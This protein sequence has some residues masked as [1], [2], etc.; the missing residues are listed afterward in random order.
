MKKSKPQ[1][2]N[3]L[4]E[5][6]LKCRRTMDLGPTRKNHTLEIHVLKGKAEL[7][8]LNEKSGT[9]KKT[10]TVIVLNKDEFAR[11]P[12]SYRLVAKTR[13]EFTTQQVRRVR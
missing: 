10:G 5:F 4:A 3:T 6:E 9:V 12:G 11:I 1:N 7:R 13:I 2:N 8:P